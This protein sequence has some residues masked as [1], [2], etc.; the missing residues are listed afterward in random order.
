MIHALKNGWVYLR[1][2]NFKVVTNQTSPCWLLSLQVPGDKLARRMLDMKSYQSE[3]IRAK[4]L[5]MVVP[6]I[7]SR[8]AVRKLL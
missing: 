3:V 8:V 7:P 6:D 4:S 2:E 5:A 1:V